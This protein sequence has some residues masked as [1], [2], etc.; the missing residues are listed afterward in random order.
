MRLLIIYCHPVPGSFNAAILKTARQA[1]DR[2][3]HE[4]RLIDL[5]DQNFSPVLSRAEH[6]NYIARPDVLIEN[7][8]EHVDALR[9]AQGFVFIF[10][11]WMHGPPAM[12]K[13]WLERTWLRGVA[14]EIA[15]RKGQKTGARMRHITRLVVITTSGAPYWWLRVIGDPCRRFFCR[16]L[17]ALFAWRCKTIYMQLHNMNTVTDQD[18]R[19]F[20]ARVERRLARL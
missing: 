17:R 13:G 6:E 16:G 8:R 2:G 9:W 20:L 19:K 14:F 10:P 7:V 3:G 1:L 4:L 18:R 5:Y 11:I 12:L 15:T